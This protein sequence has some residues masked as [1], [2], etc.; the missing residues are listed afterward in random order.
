M[1]VINEK[2]ECYNRREWMS[3]HSSMSKNHAILLFYITA[4]AATG[5]V[6][7]ITA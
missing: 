5:V 6:L 3:S 7:D 4:E 2:N 1:S